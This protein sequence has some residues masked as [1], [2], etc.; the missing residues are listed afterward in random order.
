MFGSFAHQLAECSNA[1]HCDRQSGFCRCRDGF[2]GTACQIRDCPT[3]P[4]GLYSF[5]ILQ[6][7]PYSPQGKFVAVTEF[8]SQSQNFLTVSAILTEVIL[9]C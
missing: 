5:I 6:V 1:G 8:A 9:T 4:T 2:S 7:L 3:A